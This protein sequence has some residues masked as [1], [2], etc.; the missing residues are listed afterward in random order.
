[1]QGQLFS[2]DFLTR[3]ILDTAPW[4]ALDQAR[5][6]A[7]SAE[8][9]RVY[10][11]L[12]GD[13]ALNEAQTESEL[14]EPVL[15]ALG[16]EHLPQINMSE[17]GREDVPD[18]LLFADAPAKARA[19]AEPSDDRRVRHGVALLEA[20]SWLRV[21]DRSE[22]GLTGTRKPR[23]FGAPS[24][25]MLRYLSRADVMS[26]R[27]VKWGIL[28]NGAVWR[29]Y[30]QDARSRAEDF[31]E[32]NLAALLGIPGAQAELDGYESSHGLR[33]FYLLF[34]RAAFLPQTWDAEFRTYHAIALSEARRYE[35][36]V[37][38]SLGQRVFDEVFPALANVLAASDLAAQK[39]ARGQYTRA[40]LDEVREATL[41][42]LYRMLI[43]LQALD[44][45]FLAELEV[46]VGR[47]VLLEFLE[48]LVGEV[49][50]IDQEQDAPRAGEFDQSVDEGNRGEGLARAS[51]HLDQGARAVF[52]QG[53]FEVVDRRDLGGPEAFFLER[54]HGLQLGEEGG[55]CFV[56]GGRISLSP[57]PSPACGGG[58]K[59]EPVG[60]QLGLVEGEHWARAWNRVEA[61]G[62]AGF[63][64]GGLV[65]E[66]Q[67]VAPA[68]Q[69][70]GQALGVFVGLGFDAGEGDAFLLGLD[71]PG[72]LAVHIQQV[73]GE[74]V[75][76][77]RKFTDGDATRG[78]DVGRGRIADVPARRL[79]QHINFSPSSLFGL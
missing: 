78:M 31:F 32:I 39:T 62:E 65:G 57:G 33:L 9:R 75:T 7:F 14:I 26:D 13:T 12:A 79:Q 53:F 43:A 41:V 59:G 60:Q 16:W 76:G 69:T 11:I 40:Y 8:L 44:D 52:R 42:L 67:R 19:L 49:A 68:R 30:W 3:G 58:E 35:E 10:G 25:Q 37:S 72:R 56:C 45:V 20:K 6:D 74:A 66:R 18:F 24:S 17:S 70:G 27:A 77:Q 22:P 2:H 73:I 1:M 47:D 21:L 50:A 54:R 4:H 5:L 61:V 51:G 38:Q 29:L 48:G 28:T 34:G 71:H 23:D 64:A 15:A 46:V 55:G 36:A 63:D